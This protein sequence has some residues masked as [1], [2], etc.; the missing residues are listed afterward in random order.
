MGHTSSVSHLLS[1]YRR[2]LAHESYGKMIVMR[3]GMYGIALS[4]NQARE[5]LW[6]WLIHPNS[7]TVAISQGVVLGSTIDRIYD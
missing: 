3:I 6:L 2:S 5:R 7:F 4:A 1:L